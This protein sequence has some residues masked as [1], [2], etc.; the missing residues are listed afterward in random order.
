[1][2]YSKWYR[3]HSFDQNE[4]YTEKILLAYGLNEYNFVMDGYGSYAS[5]S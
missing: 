1:M 5:L 2:V 3:K 4:E